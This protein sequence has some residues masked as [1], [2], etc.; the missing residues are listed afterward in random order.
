MVCG[1]VVVFFGRSAQEC[2]SEAE[3]LT[4]SIGE[5]HGICVYDMYVCKY[6]GVYVCI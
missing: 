2:V 4:E 6:V 1:L 3:F 5:D